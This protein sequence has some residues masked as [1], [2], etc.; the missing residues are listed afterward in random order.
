M[1]DDLE[2]DKQA[3]AMFVAEKAFHLPNV[4]KNLLEFCGAQIRGAHHDPKVNVDVAIA[5]TLLRTIFFSMQ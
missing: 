3:G 4:V 5:T 2:P 1:I